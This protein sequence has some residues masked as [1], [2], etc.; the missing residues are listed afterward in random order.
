MFPIDAASSITYA[1]TLQG[2]VLTVEKAVIDEG[3][4]LVI[5]ADAGDSTPGAVIGAKRIRE[6]VNFDVTVELDAD[7]ITETLF[8][9]L[10]YDTDEIGTYE[11]GTVDGADSPVFVNEAVV[12][13]ALEPV[14]IE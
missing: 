6:G 1:G 2:N 7:G 11:F 8:P 12:V 3:G 10:H 4:W 13:G 14:V 9:M 5:H